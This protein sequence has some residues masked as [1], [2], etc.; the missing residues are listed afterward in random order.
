MGTNPEGL[1]V[2]PEGHAKSDRKRLLPWFVLV[3]FLLV[4]VGTAVVDL[5]YPLKS[6]KLTGAENAAYKKMQADA[7]WSDGSLARLI[8]YQYRIRSRVRSEAAK[9]YATFLHRYLRE[10]GKEQLVGSD[11]WTF[12]TARVRVPQAAP[13][14]GAK[15][16]AAEQAALSRRLLSL[17][18]ELTLLPLP[19]KATVMEKHLPFGVDPRPEYD[20][21]MVATLQAFGVRTIDLWPLWSG[22][23]SE[24][25]YRKTDTHWSSLG[26]RM[27][28]EEVARQLG[29][30]AEPS[31]R[32]G[33]IVSDPR[34][35]T[36]GSF[37]RMANAIPHPPGSSVYEREKL[38]V[39]ENKTRIA[40]GDDT[41][42]IALCG[43]SFSVREE[44]AR[45]LT[46]YFG[47]RIQSVGS[48]GQRPETSLLK[49]LRA[50]QATGF[51][52]Q[53]LEE[54]PNHLLISAGLNDKHW[55]L[56]PPSRKI[57][58][59]FLPPK[60][61]E[62][63]LPIELY[64]KAIQVGETL[65]VKSGRTL[66][67]LPEG[68]IARTGQGTLE[69]GVDLLPV[70]GE[71]ALSMRSGISQFPMVTHEEW[72]RYLMP[73]LNVNET[74]GEV[75][76]SIRT[77]ARDL[78]AEFVLGGVAMV[79]CVDES[80]KVTGVAQDLQHSD[81]HV[82]ETIRFPNPPPI[83]R[84][85]TLVIQTQPGRGTVRQLQV[86][87]KTTSEGRTQEHSFA[88]LHRGGWILIDPSTLMGESLHSV[89]LRGDIPAANEVSTWIADAGYYRIR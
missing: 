13:T 89:T 28:A 84:G 52:A 41:A 88:L 24:D 38:D 53:I 85:S 8:E 76:I 45:F 5:A 81:G 87:V 34:G 77:M 60:S 15:R 82:S 31:G 54:A 33:E 16:I 50:R 10:A 78:E 11:G 18:M 63:G 73:V 27:T 55:A 57:F 37:Y 86:V 43:T 40:V 35:G 6:P 49:M 30:L 23:Q 80:T 3:T 19:R 9:P 71:V 67:K 4:L 66:A 14:L 22:E 20:H 69:I 48:P 70:S 2:L 17:G 58:G 51:P 39:F 21:A 26:L 56:T 79:T 61:K 25:V 42:P 1:I 83:V 68:W 74:A 36:P 75:L 29:R 65:R 59:E 44:F 47:E 12:L 62:L 46:H 64:P 72:G 7:T 32:L